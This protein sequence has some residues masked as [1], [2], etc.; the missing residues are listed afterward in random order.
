MWRRLQATIDGSSVLAIAKPFLEQE[1]FG[2]GLV[3]GIAG[4]IK[5]SAIALG[6]LLRTLVLAGLYDAAHAKSR[7]ALGP[8]ALFRLDAIAVELIAG[9]SLRKAYLERQKLLAELWHAITNLRQSLVSAG[10]Q[11]SRSYQGKWDQLIRL[12]QQRGLRAR[13]HEGQITGEV[14]V[15]VLMLILTVVDGV[16]AAKALSELP[17]LTKLARGLKAVA[18]TSIRAEEDGARSLARVS[19]S[20]VDQP[21]LHNLDGTKVKS[22]NFTT[23]RKADPINSVDDNAAARALEHQD[24]SDKEIDQILSSGE[25][26][27]SKPLDKDAKLYGFDSS[28]NPNGLKSQRSPYWMDEAAYKDV[29]SKYYQNGNWDREGV[30]NYLALPCYNRADVIDTA[31]VTEP[32]TAIESTIGKA[33]E[34]IGYTKGDASTGMMEK[35]MSGGGTQI[36]PNPSSISS[37]TRLSSTP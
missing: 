5:D 1:S 20:K 14:L 24:R 35:A 15:D 7:Y 37:V 29:K 21:G 10:T 9:D 34:Q 6:S 16:G 2:L 36:T 17:E 12:R 30:K 11:I 32:H 26:F 4:S 3:V 31:T 18:R 8:L 23:A 27:R 13:F 25:N 33:T 22:E 19:R 28:D